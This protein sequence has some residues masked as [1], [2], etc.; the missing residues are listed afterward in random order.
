M[1]R[2]IW[3]RA[4]GCGV[5][6]VAGVAGGRGGPP[7]RL[8]SHPHPSEKETPCRRCRGNYPL[9]TLHLL[10]G[11]DF[12][13][14]LSGSPFFF[15]RSNLVLVPPDAAGI[16]CPEESRERMRATQRLR[17]KRELRESSPHEG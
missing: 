2:K 13:G 5:A 12:Q 4:G 6:D 8:T 17:R 7:A 10:R 14:L 3:L 15:R 9:H 11:S 16:E 1:D